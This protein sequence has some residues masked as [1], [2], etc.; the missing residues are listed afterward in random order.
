VAEY[1][2]A[3][4]LLELKGVLAI[5][6]VYRA[7]RGEVDVDAILADQG[8]FHRR[9]GVISASSIGRRVIELLRPF[10]LE[11]VVHD[12]YLTEADAQRLG[13]TTVDLDTLLSTSDLVSLH[14]PLLPETTKMIGAAQLAAMRDGAV[15]L[16][17]ARGAL[18][19]EDALATELRTGRIRAVLD[20]TEPEPPAPDSPL[21]DLDNVVLTPHVAGSRGRELRRIGEEIVAELARLVRGEPLRYEV[22]PERYDTNA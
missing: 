18:I 17:T 7:A 14:T 12:P 21:W 19:D 10:D 16:N 4:I 3:M 1:T 22:S 20:V 8:N 5:E 11:I 15:L 9:V 6:K 13:A 2:V